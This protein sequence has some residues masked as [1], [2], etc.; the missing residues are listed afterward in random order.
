MKIVLERRY[1]E[2]I[3]PLE[4]FEFIDMKPQQHLCPLLLI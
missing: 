3:G 4:H 1:L 2:M